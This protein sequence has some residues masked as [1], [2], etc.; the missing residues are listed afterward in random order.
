MDMIFRCEEEI[1]SFP[2]L[3]K[4]GYIDMIRKAHPFLLIRSEFS[5]NPGL[6]GTL[7]SKLGC[8]NIADKI[9]Q[10]EQCFDEVTIAL[11]GIQIVSASPP[12][13]PFTA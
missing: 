4:S 2:K 1:S 9:N 7:S 13:T 6:G 12:L 8:T 11:I 3:L 10:L 5:G